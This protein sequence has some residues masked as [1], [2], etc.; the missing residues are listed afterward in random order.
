[1]GFIDT[2]KSRFSCRNYQERQVEEDKIAHILGAARLAPSA[3]NLQPWH[4]VVVQDPEN[5]EKIKSCYARDWINS[6]PLIIVA[7]GD[8]KGA[9]YRPDGKNHADI[10]VA[11][12]VDHLTLAAAD[13]GLG[14]CWVCKFDVLK[15]AGILQLPEGIEPI[16]MVPVGYPVDEANTER[17][18]VQRKSLQEIVHKDK[19]YYKY[20]KR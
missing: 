3:K 20:F 17:H 16:A 8:H 5:L 2:A 11:I 13:I 18:D 15:C 4:F 9:W 12:A 14:T 1:M 6:A 7:C 19:F 10:D